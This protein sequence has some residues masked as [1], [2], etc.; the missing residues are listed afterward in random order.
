MS[1]PTSINI[2]LGQIIASDNPAQIAANLKLIEIPA[3]L[4][5]IKQVQILR[6]KIT[7]KNNDEMIEIKTD[8]GVIK[9]KIMQNTPLQVGDNVEIK[10][11]KGSPPQVANIKLL[12]KI[13]AKEG[14][15]PKSEIKLP[16]RVELPQILS[17]EQLI[18]QKTIKIEL[19]TPQIVQKITA[20]YTEKIDTI[21]KPATSYSVA[22]KLEVSYKT[23]AIQESLVQIPN[24]IKSPI[25][26]LHSPPRQSLEISPVIQNN[27]KNIVASF[28]MD[29]PITELPLRVVVAQI[30]ANPISKPINIS[31]ISPPPPITAITITEIN[32]SQIS[33]P[34][35][36]ITYVKNQDIPNIK[37]GQS[38][39]VIAG[40]THDKEFPVIK[41]TVP[42]SQSEQFYAL[43]TPVK[44]IPLG[45]ELEL[46]VSKSG[47]ISTEVANNTT[48]TA[49]STS[50]NTAMPIIISQSSFISPNIWSIMQEISQVLAKANP[51]T[52]QAFSNIM[53]NPAAPANLGSAAMFFLSAMR[54]GDVQSWLGERA[55]DIIKRA[56]KSELITR[57]SGEF[58][59]LSRTSSDANTGEWR[60]LTLPLSWQ[61]EIY[62]MD[63]HYRKEGDG[64]DDD[65]QKG[66]SKT[67]FV[68][69]LNLSQMGK[70]Q[71][72]GLFIGNKYG[73][74]RLDLIL[75]TKQGFSEAMKMEMRQK[76]KSAL[77]ETSFTGDLN[78][79]NKPEQWVNITPNAQSEFLTEA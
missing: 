69:D 52:A 73:A 14:A 46:T 10:I 26:E 71:L 55:A 20:P 59:A 48:S 76:Y 56:G 68:M 27:E 58:S 2:I 66:G 4:A 42:H 45:A 12:P 17:T 29:A 72:D 13:T 61:N 50:I 16:P 39:A 78:F 63:I 60:S 62:K 18:T 15:S 51:A 41:I 30:V 37:A 70:I 38:S 7:V 19:L 34:L 31:T 25:A 43:Q 28:K 8:K 53:P 22:P 40:F 21:L 6:G 9:A 11:N 49:I 1:D 5:F 3:A 54:S 77:D 67:R 44:E 47:S 24:E 64:S 32:I 35:A 23:P 57:L 79:Q 65:E 33:P 75:R 36:Q 74:G